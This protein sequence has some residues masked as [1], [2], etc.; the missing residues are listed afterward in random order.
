MSGSLESLFNHVALPPRLP[1]KQDGR[2]E[3]IEQGLT[4]RMLDASRA[5][6]DLTS[7]RF[8]DEWN[9]I[10]RSLQACRTVNAGGKLNKASL[11]AEMRGLERQDILILHVAEQNA[12]LLI[13]RYNK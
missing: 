12:G 6:K 11:L 9:C 5:L 13:K 1:S 10:R 7:E 8:S 3:Q 2:L 4:Q